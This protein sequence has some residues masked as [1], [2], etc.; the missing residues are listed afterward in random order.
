MNSFKAPG[1]IKIHPGELLPG[2]FK[3][4]SCS[5]FNKNDEILP[6][7]TNISSVVVNIYHV[8]KS[9]VTSEF[10]PTTPTLEDNLITLNFQYP[11]IS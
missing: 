5:K 3:V 6:Y 10:L 1:Q 7:N 2:Y 11:A 8:N 4:Y 9:D